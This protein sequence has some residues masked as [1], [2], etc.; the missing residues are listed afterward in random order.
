MSF[1][2]PLIFLL[3]STF[4][5]GTGASQLEVHGA[6]GERYL[7]SPVRIVI[8]GSST[9]A[10]VGAR[11]I[12]SAWVNRYRAYL[13]R[14]HPGCQ[15]V[16]LAKSG[17]QS[18]HLLPDGFRRG[19]S[20]PAPDPEHNISRALALRPDAIIV[21][22]P[23]NDAA[24][25]YDAATQ[26]RNLEIIAHT[27]WTA[28][29][30]LWFISLQPRNF[31]SLKV[32]TQLQV[33]E[34]MQKRF[35]DRLIPVWHLLAT[36]SGRLSPHVDAGDGI[37][38]NNRGHAI[39]VEQVIAHQIP[40]QAIYLRPLYALEKRWNHIVPPTDNALRQPVIRPLPAVNL[41]LKADQ[42]MAQ[43]NI[44]VFDI[45]GR[46]LRQF[47]ADL[48]YLLVGDFGPPGVY[49][50]RMRKGEWEKTMRWIKI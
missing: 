8:L 33:L 45:N 40:F 44:S 13:K 41:L 26:V 31:D 24:A 48:P 23:S 14:L 21:N 29:V 34:A 17:Y 38:L 16:N 7:P 32:K 50:I 6:N 11:P 12:D 15:V 22:L 1:A 5:G 25:G 36:P 9:A 10:G 3:L 2:R 28:D 20:Y 4:V 39:L 43:V 42:P 30:P 46:L 49:R 19:L 18:F 37:H 35:P 47:N 27:A